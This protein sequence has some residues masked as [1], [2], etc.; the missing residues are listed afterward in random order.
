MKKS[1]LIF[2]FAIFGCIANANAQIIITPDLDLDPNS[3][4]KDI[5]AYP[6][7]VT[8]PGYYELNMRLSVM[9]N[10]GQAG[11]F[12]TSSYRRTRFWNNATQTYGAWGTWGSFTPN[13]NVFP[14]TGPSQTPNNVY[15][16][17]ARTYQ[18]EGT[19]I[20]YYVKVTFIALNG[21][22]KVTDTPI[23]TATILGVPTACFSMYNVI[24]TQNEPSYYGPMPVKTICQNAVTI[25]GSCSKFENAYHIRI[26]EFNL[27]TWTFVSDLYNNWVPGGG[28]APTFISLNALAATNGKVLT[29]GKVY[30]VNLSV[31]PT[32]NSAE[33]QFFRVITC[34]QSGSEDASELQTIEAPSDVTIDETL[35]EIKLYPNPVKDE[36]TITVNEV[37]KIVSY[38]IFDNSGNA[39]KKGEFTTESNEQKVSLN[40][41]RQGIYLLNIETNKQSYR[42][43][44]I[45]E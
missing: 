36:L 31:G 30:L 24:S 32:W 10:T 12:Y 37:E 3:G 45:K 26:S 15:G 6:N 22:Q 25:N 5:T 8:Y 28:E 7:S 38:S 42:E 40:E 19:Q 29:P 4:S 21:S 14:N 23:H 11:R 16:G 34:R 35:Q 20:E 18:L 17:T 39:V 41:L 13:M 9:V 27:A 44:I 2:L 43:K 33:A 1:I